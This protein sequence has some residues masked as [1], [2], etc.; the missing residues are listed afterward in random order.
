MAIA[1]DYPRRSVV[2][3]S[4]TWDVLSGLLPLVLLVGF[5]FFLTRRSGTN[6]QD[7][8]AEK[9]DEIRDELVRIRRAL[10][11]RDL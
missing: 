5:W 6:P 4:T 7:M 9:L 10:E 2:L 11:Q 1:G 3:A 8:L